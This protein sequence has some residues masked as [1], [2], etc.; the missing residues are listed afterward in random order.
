MCG[1]TQE[2]EGIGLENRQGG[3]PLQEFKSLLPRHRAGATH[4]APAQMYLERCSLTSRPL[5]V[6]TTVDE[7]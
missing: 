1:S 6:T 4:A 3:K 5:S 2:A 7:W